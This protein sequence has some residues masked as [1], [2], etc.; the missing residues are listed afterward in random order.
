[1]RYKENKER[2]SRLEFFATAA[3]GLTAGA[4]LMKENGGGKAFSKAL[5]NVVEA[6]SG[7]S[8][9]L[10]K[11]SFKEMDAENISKIAKNRVLNND[12]TY[13]NAV[14]RSNIKSIDQ[15]RGLFAAIR[16]FE[17]FKNK[18]THLD[19]KIGDNIQ[20]GE[21]MKRMQ[22]QFKNESQEFFEQAHVLTSEVLNNKH[23]YFESANGDITTAIKS[24]F[25][26][27][28]VGGMFEDSSG[29]I[30]GIFEDALNGSEQILANMQTQYESSLHPQLVKKYE[31]GLLEKYSKNDDFFKD[32]LDRAA[33]VN[34]FLSAVSDN[35]IEMTDEVKEMADTLSNLV[36]SDERYGSL[37][38]DSKTLRMDKNNEIYSLLSMNNATDL[39]KEE[40][41]DTIVGKLFGMRSAL[42]NKQ[43]PDF[44]YF[45]QG[46]YDKILGSLTGSKS[47]LLE[48]DHF[49]IG[50]KTFQYKD[51]LLSHLENADDIYLMGGK[52]GPQASIANTLFGNTYSNPISNKAAQMLDIGTKGI[53]TFREKTSMMKKFKEDSEWYPNVVKRLI[54]DKYDHAL[55]NE[56]LM[57]GFFK[58]L[59]TVNKM[60]NDQ[61]FA[62]SVRTVNKLKESMTSTTGRALLNSIDSD[63][64]AASILKNSA[65]DTTKL[66]NKDLITLLN[67]YKN[68]MQS[69]KQ[70]IHIGDMKGSGGGK[71]IL[72]YNK[73]LTR[74]VVKESLLRESSMSTSR[75]SGYAMT[76]GKIEDLAINGKDK[77]HVKDLLN[78]S[79]LQKEGDLFSATSHDQ[80]KVSFK[81]KQFQN[82][83]D[84]LKTRRKNDQEQAFLQSFQDGLKTFSKENSSAFESIEG[85]NNRII[86]PFETGTYVSMRKAVGVNDL[87]KSMND[88][89]KFKATAK[90]FGK[91]MYAG[92]DNV[93]D[94]TTAT[95]LPFHML[96]RLTTS[97]E[98]INLGFSKESTKSIG[99]LA[100][101]IGLKRVLPA[102]GIAYAYSYLNY[103]AENFT[104]TSL[105][106]AKENA[107]ANLGLGAKTIT[108]GLGLSHA[109]RRSRAYNPIAKYWGGDYK[110]KDEY[111]DYLEY[112]YDPIRKG[113]FWSFGSSS[114]FRGSKVSYWKPNDLRLAHSNYYDVN[115]YGSSEE[116]WKHSWMPSLRHPL[117]TLKA[118]SNPYWLEEKHY[119][120][121]P[122][123]VSAKLFADGTPWGAVLNP[124]IGAIIKP[125][126]RMHKREM[127]GTLTDVRTL[128]ADRNNDI[129]RRSAERSMVRL[130]N[131]G[132]T[133][134][135]FNPSSMPSMSEAVFNI[136]VDGGRV[137]SAGFAGQQH[138]ESVRDINSAVIPESTESIAGTNIEAGIRS[139]SHM[140]DSGNSDVISSFASTMTSLVHLG[141]SSGAVKS[142][143][144]MSMIKG[145]NNSIFARAESGRQGIINEA[146][147]LHTQPFR[148]EA[149]SSKTKYL[150]Q[151]ISGESKN[152]F[153]HDIMYS[154]K[155]L[156]GM[157]GFLSGQ[158]LPESKGYKLE[159]ANMTSFSNRFWD[160]SVGGIGGDFM[161]IARRFFPHSDHNIE[162]INTIKNTMPEWM[163]ERFL[164]GDPYNKLPLGDARLPGA[165]Y[166]T[167]NKLHSDQYGRYGAFDRYKILADISPN[168][169]E[170]KTWKKIAKE[171]VQDP[172]LKKQMEQIE[173][174]VKEQTKEHDFYN[175]KFLKRDLDSKSAVIETV[176]NTG[177][178]TIVGSDQQY[179]LAGIKPLSDEVTGSYVHEYL[180]AGM[181]VEL[182]YEDNEFRNRDRK[183]NIS[184]LVYAHGESISRQMFEDKK[185]NEKQ[186]KETLADEY[187]SLKDSNISMGHVYE[188]IG[189]MP[190]PFLHNKF[191]RIDSPMESYRKEQ[192]YGTPFSTWDHPIEGFIKPAFQYAWGQGIGFQALGMSTFLL[193]NYARNSG[194]SKGVKQLAH[195]AFALTNPGGFAGGVIGAI[196][197]MSW[198]SE[199]T[200]IGWNSKN[201]ANAGAVIG[202]VGYGMA[203]LENPFLSAGNFAVAG[204][205]IGNQLKE[206]YG[207][208]GALI[209]AAVGVGLSALKNPEFSL[210]KLTEKYIPKDTKKKWEI[211]E[212][213]DRLEYLKYNNLFEKAAKKAKRKEGI[214]VKKIVNKFEYSREKNID[215]IRELTEKKINVQKTILDEEVRDNLVASIDQQIYKL[216]TPEQYF[217]MGEYT[218]AALAYKKAA[219]TTIYGLSDYA[220]GADVLRAL[221][222]YDRDF[223]LEFAK[224]KDPNERKKLLKY[225]SP[226]KQKALKV[227]WKEDIDKDEHE[228]NK[229]FFNTHKL[230][231]LAWSGWNPRV[232]LD[233]VKMK[234]IENEGMLLSDFGIYESSKN[235]PAYMTSPEISNMSQPSSPLAIQR[236]LLG[237]L[238]GAGLQNVD[239]SVDQSN[240]SGF[241]IVSNISRIATYDIQEKVRSTLSNIF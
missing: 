107:L 91:Q 37:R 57:S 207:G 155:Q 129:K 167:L 49:K 158:I 44:Y 150:E 40:V 71:N 130:D 197:R 4:F 15:S 25:D 142:G 212:Y 9:D 186:D 160:T 152:D 119:N 140:K 35:K 46:T 51:G 200:R 61:T 165:G 199:A 180:K 168:T 38:V 97:L 196:P 208:K 233:N 84:L 82:I 188:A 237:L 173:K 66:Q 225:I 163:P 143:T 156:S 58:D 26:L 48:Y 179:T 210:G 175:Y 45:G 231:S 222:K 153:V 96:N 224:E 203:N 122:Y 219:D 28:T 145:V 157:Y 223:F 172:F 216:Q 162:Q 228:S 230:P 232:N 68:N 98:A 52:H 135:A 149:E 86:K 128:I 240:E 104:G 106:E 191:L 79:V 123:P 10:A 201:F 23:Q 187:F 134:M 20:A 112:G 31:E 178:F 89:I 213:F 6:A 11:L 132:F 185:G 133:P 36:A 169:E 8:D 80:F 90:K 183:G 81:E 170:Y 113:R 1:M 76:K 21:V 166:E 16:D 93:N 211:E 139:N 108:D 39:A 60:Y 7:I 19:D 194:A 181:Q 87:L 14:T 54:G 174:R 12:S 78:W 141:V 193:S 69:V 22:A 62:P 206:G 154:G 184:S 72:D 63:N 70:T 171:E 99:D 176:S 238:N 41:A 118:I 92:R 148:D 192:I 198:S 235:E 56:P 125:E 189:H 77:K 43:A 234:T 126:K 159:Q 209:G 164:T 202:A 18:G 47:G 5:G 33:E 115:V 151:M 75:V 218:K 27:A 227:L 73:L 101:S 241:Q 17:S 100:K 53:S 83:N 13:K 95:L 24:E 110:D 59:K 55:G 30:A 111:L 50:S 137:T 146:A 65:I 182:K 190:I 88:E 205:A 214:D 220:S 102:M 2:T 32:T 161:E 138:A 3:A 131:A 124:T 74:E 94:V 109:G 120:D 42:L 103:E 221:P 147:N 116:K 195:T 144:A 67:K 85:R 64:I 226:Y 29:K 229:S 127:G 121:R 239:I 217:G 204:M 105:T 177:G 136:K 215:K 236:D 114:E 117:S 34:D